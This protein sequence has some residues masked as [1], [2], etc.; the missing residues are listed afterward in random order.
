MTYG[1]ILVPTWC[2][3]PDANFGEIGCCSL[4]YGY[5][6]SKGYCEKCECFLKDDNRVENEKEVINNQITL[7]AYLDLLK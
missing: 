1:D 6:D 3:Y 4:I 5:I 2:G 7:R